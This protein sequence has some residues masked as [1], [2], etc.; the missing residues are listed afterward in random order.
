M[1]P[2]QKTRILLTEDD[3]GMAH[4]IQL[5]MQTLNT[6]YTLDIAFSAEEG[7]HMWRQQPYDLILTDYNL[8]GMHG[9][10]L[11]T[12]L[13]QRGSTAPAV[14]FT[15]YASANLQAEA[16]A[17]NAMYV[18]KPFFIDQFIDLIRRLLPNQHVEVGKEPC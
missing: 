12:L 1:L 7:L 13:R 3:Q 5:A 17:V 10:A 16:A 15:A 4:A 18:I 6:P 8:R 11:I 9:L 2:A 14:L